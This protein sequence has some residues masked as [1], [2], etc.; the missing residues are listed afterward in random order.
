MVYGMWKAKAVHIA[1]ALPWPSAWSRGDGG[2][3]EASCSGSAW[4]LL[5][6]G[7]HFLPGSSPASCLGF[8]NRASSLCSPQGREG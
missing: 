7:K 2:G 1:V 6:T 3:Q 8:L 5:D 4:E